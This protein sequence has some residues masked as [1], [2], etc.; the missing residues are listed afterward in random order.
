MTAPGGF[1]KISDFKPVLGLYIDV[2]HVITFLPHFSI[3]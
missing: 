2:K 1:L 3:N